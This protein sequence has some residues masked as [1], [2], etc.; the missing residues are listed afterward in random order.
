MPFLTVDTD[1]KMVFHEFSDDLMN[2]LLSNHPEYYEVYSCIS[3]G[4][5]NAL[6]SHFDGHSQH[7]IKHQ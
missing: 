1:G 3:L 4:V 6:Y 7:Q 2:F 5:K